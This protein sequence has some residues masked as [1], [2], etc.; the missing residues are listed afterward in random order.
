M[1]TRLVALVMLPVTVICGLAGTVLMSHQAQV[2][3]ALA[4]DRGTTHLQRLVEL[5]NGLQTMRAIGSFEVRFDQLGV[6]TA[7][8]ADLLGFDPTAS[9]PAAR[10]KALR[11]AVSLASEDPRPE[12]SLRALYTAIDAGEIGFGDAVHRL[13]ALIATNGT[14]VTGT[15]DHMET[16]AGDGPVHDALEALRAA[17]ELTDVAP[18]QGIELSAIWFPARGDTPSDA[19]ATNVRFGR[20]NA[21]YEIAASRLEA[22]TSDAL[23]DD[24]ARLE[25]TP[26]I[27]HF[28]RAV[29]LTQL[30]VVF[31]PPG[32]PINLPEVRQ[33]FQ[34]F[35]ARAEALDIVETDANLAVR[36]EARQLAA[37]ER[38]GFIAWLVGAALLALVSVGVALRLAHSIARPLKELA[39]Y[40]D[41]VNDGQLDAAPDDPER[42]PTETR[43]AFSAFAAL[44]TN[45][46]L[47]DAKANA[48]ALCDFQAPVLDEPLP[49]RL[50]RS[51]ESSV[52]LLSGSIVERDELQTHL[53]HQATHDALTGIANRS[54]AINAIHAAIQDAD[55]NGT[56][57]ALL[58]I[59]LNHFKAVNDTHGHEGGDEI[60]RQVADRLTATSRRGD[61]VARLGGDEFVIVTQRIGGDVEAIEM[62]TRILESITQPFDLGGVAVSIGLA[63]G[64]AMTGDDPDEPFGLLARADA[65]MYRAK[66]HPRSAIEV[67]D[68][69]LQREMLERGDIESALGAALEDPSG[70]GLQLHYQPVLD[71]SSG[72]LVGTEAL[73]RWDRPGRGL[74]P[75][76]AFIPVAEA[77]TLIIDLDRWVLRETTRQLKE[78]TT[79]EHLSEIPVAVNIS[80]RHLRSAQLTDHVRAALDETGIDA[81]RL[82]IEVT[83]TVLLTDLAIAA[84][85]LRAVRALGVKVAIDDF[86]TGYTSLAQL[87]RLPIDTIKIDRSFVSQIHV[88]RGNSLVRMITD[89]GHAID[90]N[91]IAEGVETQEEMVALQA[92]GVDDLQGWLFS[93]A[94]PPGELEL[95]AS[96]H[97]RGG[98]RPA[99]PVG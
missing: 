9:V 23:V 73:I 91:I 37:S 28:E 53:T 47:L 89:L 59:D 41:A 26:A 67:F 11:A 54:S 95:W 88:R 17:N 63:I 75:P 51:L 33:T 85:E 76:D 77:S 66:G 82:S 97:L 83:E 61:R 15:L 3:N 4:V 5:Q 50:G 45:L 58:F 57:A 24:L 90:T 74:L 80:G 60:L 43:A 36:H 78:W 27:R 18:S 38:A 7:E 68:A 49:G 55:E 84:E 31:T 35:V 25:K 39:R 62:A 16:V 8:V 48:L 13:D 56:P 46:Q 10:T 1:T 81:R 79:H 2:R 96:A 64:I 30:G 19:Q 94:L 34:G 87:Q 21:A 44:V 86:G 65:A 42:G 14:A 22:R 6:S 71:A 29:R 92:M 40:A 99:V 70:G 12:R 69:D 32:E 52:A 72:E 93:K 98:R 20:A